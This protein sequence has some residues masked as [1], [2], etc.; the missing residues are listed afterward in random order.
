M[1]QS[2]SNTALLDKHHL[3]LIEKASDAIKSL[4]TNIGWLFIDKDIIHNESRE[5]VLNELKFMLDRL[6][7]PYW[8][9]NRIKSISE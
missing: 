7:G 4:S 6:Y 9:D 5:R 1:M 3:I 8:L 2:P